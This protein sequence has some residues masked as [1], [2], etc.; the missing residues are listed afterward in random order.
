MPSDCSRVL[1]LFPGVS[2]HAASSRNPH[3]VHQAVRVETMVAPRGFARAAGGFGASAMQG[4]GTPDSRPFV[5]LVEVH[6]S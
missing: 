1:L 6:C 5:D 3:F 2:W 4:C